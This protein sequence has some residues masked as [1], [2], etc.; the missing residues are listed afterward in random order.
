[1][2]PTQ[3]EKERNFQF[4]ASY[5]AQFAHQLP[6]KR[7]LEAQTLF[8]TVSWKFYLDLWFVNCQYRR[9]TN[10]NLEVVLTKVSMENKLN[11][12]F[13]D[14]WEHEAPIV[15]YLHACLHVSIWSFKNTLGFLITVYFQDSIPCARYGLRLKLDSSERW[16]SIW[17]R[18][19][20]ATHRPGSPIL[21]ITIKFEHCFI[22]HGMMFSLLMIL[23][24]L[25]QLELYHVI[26]QRL[27]FLP[28]KSHPKIDEL[29][30][31]IREVL[32]APVFSSAPA[33]QRWCFQHGKVW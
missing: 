10:S 12:H 33:L 25:R 27:S 11:N 19:S 30:E 7:E 24:I 21:Q 13:R 9:W 18:G 17:W 6:G 20:S 1:M 29:K 2:W 26:I 22:V 8:V 23:V 15:V 5:L 4:V 14:D 31:I 28:R 3:V 32:K 16:P